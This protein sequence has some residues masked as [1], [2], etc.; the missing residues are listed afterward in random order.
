[1]GCYL[2]GPGIAAGRHAIGCDA[3]AALCMM[4]RRDAIGQKQGGCIS[5][6]KTLG[7]VAAEL[8]STQLNSTQWPDRMT[9]YEPSRS[10]RTRC[11]STRSSG[12][13]GLHKVGRC[14][15]TGHDSTARYKAAKPD[16]TPQSGGTRLDGIGSNEAERHD[17][18]TP[19]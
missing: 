1:M 13:T 15:W 8:D 5:R 14:G 10:G 6:H 17:L 16:H 3:A 2:I 18:T 11:F 19:N 4:R 7:D 9:R 12:G